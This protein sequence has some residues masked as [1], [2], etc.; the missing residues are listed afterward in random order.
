MSPSSSAAS[1][2]PCPSTSPASSD[3]RHRAAAPPALV[4]AA[5][6]TGRL[7]QHLPPPR[8][9]LVEAP[10]PQLARRALRAG[11]ASAAPLLHQRSH[12][13]ELLRRESSAE[14]GIVLRDE[15]KAAGT[16]RERLEGLRAAC[17]REAGEG[18]G[19]VVD[20]LHPV[21]ERRPWVVPLLQLLREPRRAHALAACFIFGRVDTKTR[22][23][24][25]S[26]QRLA[27]AKSDAPPRSR[28]VRA[29]GA[30][31][32]VPLRS[33]NGAPA[34]SSV[35]LSYLPSRAPSDRSRAAAAA[36]ARRRPSSARSG[37]R[38]CRCSRSS[39]QR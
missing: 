19:V 20:A 32:R 36:P 7:L 8:Q 26:P 21:E 6:L 5:A 25:T 12:E 15:T 9:R 39:G 3:H 1:L 2:L 28:N 27:A 10:A 13:L 24:A 22:S 37:R 34:T 11:A 35:R 31:A 14:Q 17:A 23:A 16:R 33:R 38:W 29:E 18:G 4:A 30:L